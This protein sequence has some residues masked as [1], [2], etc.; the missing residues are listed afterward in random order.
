MVNQ[1][2]YR[3]ARWA[4]IQERFVPFGPSREK[5][6]AAIAD[7]WADRDATGKDIGRYSVLALSNSERT[8]G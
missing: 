2:T 6:V 3:A 4:F 5:E 7:M 1:T 8:D